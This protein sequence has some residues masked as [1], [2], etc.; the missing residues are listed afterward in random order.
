RSERGTPRGRRAGSACGRPACKRPERVLDSTICGSCSGRRRGSARPARASA[1]RDRDGLRRLCT[2]SMGTC[3]NLPLITPGCESRRTS[4][5]FVIGSAALIGVECGGLDNRQIARPTGPL[6]P[7][8][9]HL[10]R[11][12]LG[13]AVRGDKLTQRVRLPDPLAQL[14][15]HELEEL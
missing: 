9:E 7:L 11:P 1:T 8:L 3:P 14:V 4:S 15:E 13:V 10:A 5:W 2:P 6:G 12:A